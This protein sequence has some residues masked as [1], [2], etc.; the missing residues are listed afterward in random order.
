MVAHPR[1]NETNSGEEQRY[2]HRHVEVK[3]VGFV[4]EVE[5]AQRDA[6]RDHAPHHQVALDVEEREDAGAH[7]VDGLDAVDVLQRYPHKKQPEEGYPSKCACNEP[8]QQHVGMGQKVGKPFG[9]KHTACK[10]P[11]KSGNQQQVALGN[12]RL[13]SGGNAYKAIH[14]LLLFALA[15]KGKSNKTCWARFNSTK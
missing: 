14:W 8:N 1:P 11:H 2:A 4:D 15:K 12:S 13:Y 6:H 9:K 5:V 3:E 7:H 10:T